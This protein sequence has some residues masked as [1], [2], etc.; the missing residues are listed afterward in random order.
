[1]SGSH[2]TS[3]NPNAVASFSVRQ[4]WRYPVKSMQG[5]SCAALRISESGIDHDRQLAVNSAA[6][7]LGSGKTSG[8]FERMDGLIEFGASVHLE[9]IL[10]HLP[11]G[12]SLRHVD[13]L[14]LPELSRLLGKHVTLEREGKHMHVDVAPVHLL[15]TSS[16]RW[17]Q[18]A[19]PDAAI[20]VR[21]F[22]PNVLIDSGVE[23]MPEQ[24]WVGRRVGV[25]DEVTLEVI[26]PT[27]RCRMV[28]FAQRG[29]AAD[30]RILAYL[31]TNVGAAFGVYARVVAGGEV[32]EG[33]GVRVL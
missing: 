21:R 3:G 23:G 31:A 6:G 33:D 27:I 29:L 1:M 26:K 2:M 30:K 4:L 15:T 11:D 20:D 18:S 8:R 12:R 32:R 24:D 22:R 16:L 28:S 7:K 9:H 5:E 19:L 14:L 10:V 25:G 13:P 17:L